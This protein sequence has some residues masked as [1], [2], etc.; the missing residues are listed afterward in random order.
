MLKGLPYVFQTAVYD[1]N[2][3]IWWLLVI[4]EVLNL[5]SAIQLFDYDNAGMHPRYPFIWT[6]GLIV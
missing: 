1:V 4:R 5:H 2:L 3:Y 6:R